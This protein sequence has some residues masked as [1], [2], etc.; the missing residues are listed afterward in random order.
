MA[1]LGLLYEYRAALLLHLH[2]EVS[3]KYDRSVSIVSMT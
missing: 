1:I 3:M 2:E